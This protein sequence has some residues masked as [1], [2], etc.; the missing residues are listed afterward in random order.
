[1]FGR[2]LNALL[3]SQGWREDDGRLKSDGLILEGD[4]GNERFVCVTLDADNFPVVVGYRFQ[5][6]ESGAYD[7]WDLGPCI[8]AAITTRAREWLAKPETSTPDFEV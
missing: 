1:M 2:A 4:D 5:G 3:R 8:P 6:D 7:A